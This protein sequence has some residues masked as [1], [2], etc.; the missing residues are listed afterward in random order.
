MSP[1]CQELN[2]LYSFAVDGGSVKIPDRLA[3][4]PDANLSDP[5]VLDELHNAAHRFSEQFHQ[6][7]VGS[8]TVSQ[9]TKDVAVDIIVTLLSSGSATM[10]E[11]ELVCKAAAIARRYSIDFGRYLSHVD[12]SALA[13]AEKYALSSLLGLNELDH[14]Y[15]W[16]RWVYL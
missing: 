9:I 16:N 12:F 13:T 3:K 4:L 7:D 15:I 11:Y 2:A 14:P 5:Y 8:T 1:E 6:T 10:S